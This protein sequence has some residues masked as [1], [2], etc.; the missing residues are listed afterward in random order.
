MSAESSYR[1]PNCF[2]EWDA[3]PPSSCPR[4]SPEGVIVDLQ[5]NRQF[6]TGAQRNESA[7]KGR[8]DLLPFAALLELSKHYE[9]G[10]KKFGDNNWMKGMPQSVFIDSGLRHLMQYAK[11]ETDE[12]HLRAAAW[13]IL[14]ALDQRERFKAGTLDPKLNNVPIAPQ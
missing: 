1:C 3:I 8:C 6:D 11:G 2:L 7:G 5:K 12:D 13:N 4:C 9:A 14:N 10:G